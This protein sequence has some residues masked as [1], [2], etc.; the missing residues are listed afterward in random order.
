MV[1]KQEHE[2]G[3]CGYK[4]CFTNN[5]W[6]PKTNNDAILANPCRHCPNSVRRNSATLRLVLKY[7][8]TEHFNNNLVRKNYFNNNL[9]R[10][11]DRLKSR[12]SFALSA[13]ERMESFA[14]HV[15]IAQWTQH[16]WLEEWK[17][18][19]VP[20]HSLP[21][22]KV[23]NPDLGLSCSAWCKLNHLRTRVGRFRESL[24]Q[25]KMAPDP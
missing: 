3:G 24:N 2:G 21:P 11:Q 13:I 4:F 18:S 19:G 12:R 20:P 23:E 14:G 6:M 22:P 15:S 8:L 17:K 10:K 7:A 9:V 25:W 5:Y 1:K 16:Q